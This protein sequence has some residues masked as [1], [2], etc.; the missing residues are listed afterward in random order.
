MF[1]RTSTSAL[2]AAAYTL[3]VAVNASPDAFPFTNEP[4]HQLVNR[5]DVIITTGATGGVHPRLEI[6]NLATRDDEW[7]LYIKTMAKWQQAGEDDT[8]GYYGVA[9]IHGVPLEDWNGA[10]QC[11][12]CGTATGYGTHDMVIFPT[13]HR[14]YLSHFEQKFLDAALE[15]AESYPASSRARMVAAQ[16][17]LRFPY[18]DWAASPESNSTCLPETITSPQITINGPDGAETLDNPLYKFEFTESEAKANYYSVFTSWMQT[19]RYPNTND[20]DATSDDATAISALDG[21]QDSLKDQVYQM[22]TACDDY[23]HFSNDQVGATSK[24]ANSLEQIHNTVHTLAGGA[25]NDG[26]SSGHLTYL[27]LSTY[28]PVFWLHHANVDRLF[29]LWQTIN[30]DSFVPSAT[31]PHSTWVIP[32]GASLNG[33]YPLE[34]FNKDASSYW[35]SN[36]I[37]DWTVLGYTYPE[38]TT[39]DGEKSDIATYVNALY[40]NKPT[41]SASDISAQIPATEVTS[42]NSTKTPSSTRNSNSTGLLGGLLGGSKSNLTLPTYSAPS[43]SSSSTP[44]IGGGLSSLIDTITS[45]V[46]DLLDSFID[47][48]TGNAYEYSCNIQTPRYALNGSYYVY[49]FNG[50]PA[51]DSCASWLQDKNL[52]GMMGVLSSPDAM[53]GHDMLVTG[54]IPLTR[55]LR[56]LVTIGSLLGMD[57]E[58]IIPFLTKNLEWRISKNGKE[59]DVDSV[60]GFQASVYSSQAS[61]PKAVGELPSY[62]KY[63]PQVDVTKGKTGGAS[64]AIFGTANDQ[65][66]DSSNAPSY[67]SGSGSSAVSS[68]AASKTDVASHGSASASTYEVSPT[69]GAPSYGSGSSAASYEAS[70]SASATGAYSYGSNAPSASSYMSLDTPTSWATAPAGVKPSAYQPWNTVSQAVS[71]AAETCAVVTTTVKHV[72]TVYITESTPAATAPVYSAPS[73]VSAPASSA[74]SATAP[75]YSAPVESAPVYS[76]K[77]VESAPVESSPVYTTKPVESAPV[78]S[79]PSSPAAPVYSAPSSPAAPVYSAPSS[80]AAPVYSAPSSPAAPVYS[81]PASSA[82]SPS[83]VTVVPVPSTSSAFETSPVSASAPAVYPSAGASN[84]VPAAAPYPVPSGSSAAYY[85]TGTGSPVAPAY[86]TGTGKVYPSAPAYTGAANAMNAAGLFAGIGAV[87]AFFM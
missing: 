11:D 7:A 38:F 45:G 79:A 52:I 20:A 83:V 50:A 14:L 42:S 31:A 30:P 72:E 34:P 19:Y 69:N 70:A 49:V 27:P 5:A 61:V 55:S 9:S 51:S 48:A 47:A 82:P 32:S 4:A 81:A 16:K 41:L 74:P 25:G 66:D 84:T 76:S 36:E 37:R 28:D 53:P 1:S 44:S 67:G 40:G 75:A 26:T 12:S 10:K 57:E 46:E 21:M 78:Y 77:P 3:F 18:W 56:G 62:T 8:S 15:V 68:Y 59:V 85:P 86:A 13:W 17:T 60:E 6:G 63:A 23:L 64:K 71:Q 65:S 87:V 80:P 73:S 29:A 22:L 35:T 54:Q 43:S 58:K 2:A 33:D 39:S 24:C